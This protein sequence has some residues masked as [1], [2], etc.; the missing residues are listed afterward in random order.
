MEETNVREFA[1]RGDHYVPA[2]NVHDGRLVIICQYDAYCTL[3]LSLYPFQCKN[4]DSSVGIPIRLR[5]GQ[6]GF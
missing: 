4:R 6:L 2:V 1:E 3:S 5:A